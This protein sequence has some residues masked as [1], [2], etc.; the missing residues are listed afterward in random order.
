MYINITSIQFFFAEKKKED[1]LRQPLLIASGS[2]PVIL[3]QGNVAS[4]C[5]CRP[6]LNLIC[7][8]KA[9]Q[10]QNA[11]FILLHQHFNLICHGSFLKFLI[12]LLMNVYTVST[13]VAY[14]T[15]FGFLFNTLVGLSI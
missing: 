5:R 11:L 3:N 12:G 7:Q 14:I 15:Q 2:V 6:T 1:E 4:F 9:Q 8:K 10:V 13:K